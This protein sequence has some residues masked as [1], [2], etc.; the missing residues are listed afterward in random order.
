MSVSKDKNIHTSVL[1][2][3]L[4][5]AIEV[6]KERRNIVV[7]CTL[8]LAGHAE[9]MIEKLHSWDI[10]IG[11]DADE[12]N[13]KLATKRLE[14]TVQKQTQN[15]TS[16]ETPHGVKIVL[17]HTNFAELKSSLSEIGIEKVTGI[18]YDLW[19]S[20][21]HFDEAER[22]FSLRQEGPLD[23]RFDASVWSTAADIINYKSEQELA[24]IFFD[25]GEEK[26]S[27]K[28][29]R[30]LVEVR[31]NKKIVTTTDL[32]EALESVSNHPKTKTRIYQA[33]RIEVNKELFTLEKSLQ[34][35]VEILESWGNI[36]VISFHSLEDRI[37]KNIF[38]KESRD[39]YCEDI[40]CT[41]QHK[42]TLQIISKKPIL[43]W[44]LEQKENPRSRS[45]K[46]RHAQKI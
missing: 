21:M 31:K 12:R 36:F 25:Y 9:K 2:H 23:M 24:K 4:V 39:C 44:I 20:S 41:C 17:L 10:F 35:A 8:G 22:G 1:L 15:P 27:K 34:D 46:A 3:E 29:A 33:L 11:I 40:I 18:Y 38:R 42:K 13:L 45:A 5:E 30:H 28:I 14:T 19:V 7:D 16:W 26:A 6:V 43:P 32:N 37:V